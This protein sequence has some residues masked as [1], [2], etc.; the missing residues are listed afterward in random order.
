MYEIIKALNDKI[1]WKLNKFVNSLDI[2]IT[3]KEMVHLKF[4]DICL[5]EQRVPFIIYL[6]YDNKDW[7]DKYSFKGSQLPH[8]LLV[9]KKETLQIPEEEEYRNKKVIVRKNK[10]TGALDIY[11]Y[12]K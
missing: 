6:E 9:F 11:H 10:F 2:Q 4:L 1:I 12:N 3:A 8:K 5:D 7:N